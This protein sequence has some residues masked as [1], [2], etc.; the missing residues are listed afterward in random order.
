MNDEIKKVT[1]TPKKCI[2]KNLIFVV[3]MDF[4]T[5]EWGGGGEIA[6]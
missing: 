1:L 4:Q 3:K 2:A 5:T 6:K